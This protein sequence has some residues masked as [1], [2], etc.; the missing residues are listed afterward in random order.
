MAENDRLARA[1]VLVVDLGAVLRGDRAHRFASFS[2]GQ[3]SSSGS[4]ARVSTTIIRLSQDLL[5]D[6]LLEPG[7]PTLPSTSMMPRTRLRCDLPRIPLP[8]TPVNKPARGRS[9]W[10]WRLCG[11][12]A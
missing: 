8:R 11:S 4:A 6:P 2:H 1:P 12:G 10:T 3:E 9:S 7:G 5:P